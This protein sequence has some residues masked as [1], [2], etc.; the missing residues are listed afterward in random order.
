M[1]KSSRLIGF[2]QRVNIWWKLTVSNWL[3]GLMSVSWN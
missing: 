3:N 2:L 1:I